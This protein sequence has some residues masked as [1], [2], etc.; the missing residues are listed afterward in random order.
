[1]FANMSIVK[2]IL[3]GAEKHK[4]SLKSMCEELDIKPADIY[5]SDIQ[6]PFDKAYKVWEIAVKQTDDELLGL[7]L[8]EETY[9]SIMGLVGYLMQSSPNLYEAFKAV[10][11]FGRLT[12]DMFS[13]S[14]SVSGDEA[15]LSYEPCTPWIKISPLSA[16]QGTELAM[17]GTLNVFKILAGRK[18]YPQKVLL[19][20]NRQKDLSEYERVFQ[21]PIKW[22]ANANTLVFSYS[23]L[24]MPVVSY[25][26]S[27][28]GVFC[29][30][31]KREFEKVQ[32]ETFTNQVKREIMTTFM[33]QL[34]TV[35]SMAARFNMTVRSLQRKLEDENISYR[36]LCQELGKD[37]AATLLANKNLKIIEV[38]SAL[39]YSDARAFQRAFKSWTGQSP[40]KFRESLN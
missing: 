37:F 25:D 26:K 40:G 9:P 4:A 23:Q 10:C 7:H 19:S 33:G 5:H 6:V 17:A 28:M 22:N 27:L 20:Y 21:A 3:L 32:A 11:T 18:L 39:G 31:I 14:I 8:G 36:Q 24:L 35:E 13:Y 2:D 15:K 16:R 30:L 1:M 12:I 34:P 38:A 29:D